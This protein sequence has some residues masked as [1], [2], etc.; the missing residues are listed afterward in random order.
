[1]KKNILENF[2]NKVFE[3][4][5]WVK[6]VMYIKL[7]KEMKKLGCEE[8]LKNHPEQL[9]STYIPILTYKGETELFD[10][11]CGLDNNIYNFIQCCADGLC[12][13]EISVN[14]FLTM[15][16]TAKY[17]VFCVEQNFIKKPETD[18]V[19]EMAEFISGKIVT[20]ENF[21]TESAI[22]LKNE[23]KK[24]LILDY[25]SLPAVKTEYLNDNEKYK[26][27][28][29]KLKSE[30]AKLKQKLAQLLNLVKKDV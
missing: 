15:E 24:R 7:S 26:E 1:M 29:N 4:P 18:E 12:L 6:Q 19:Y 25:N 22:R 17:F 3:V 16:E 13:L 14:S 10:K 30:N 28:I 11:K 27:E 5:L 8:F 2:L 9:F 23:A 20:G 21:E